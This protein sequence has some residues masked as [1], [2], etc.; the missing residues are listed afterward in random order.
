MH[1]ISLVIEHGDHLGT[2]D[3]SDIGSYSISHM[4]RKSVTRNYG[5]TKRL[6]GL[7]KLGIVFD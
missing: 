2:W 3:I 1:H 5:A 4:D 6:E 7:D